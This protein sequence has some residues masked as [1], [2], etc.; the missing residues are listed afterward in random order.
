MSND[1]AL[2]NLGEVAERVIIEGD[3]ARLSA[4][5]RARY[6]R[7]VCDSLGLNHLTRPFGYITLNGKLTLYALKAC[8]D[9]LRKLHGVSITSIHKELRQDVYCVT[10]HA[11][12]G[13]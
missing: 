1:I 5:D 13:V 3:L 8:T 11:K 9:Q 7:T 12:D 6:Y 4:E 10:A 2:K